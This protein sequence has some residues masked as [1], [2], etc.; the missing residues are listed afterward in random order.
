[1]ALEV[2]GA[3]SCGGWDERTEIPG[4]WRRMRPP[5][6][7]GFPASGP[8]E[9]YVVVV[10][11]ALLFCHGAF[12]YAHQLSPRRMRPRRTPH[13]R[14]AVTSQIRLGAQPGCISQTPTS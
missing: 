11:V 1:L 12:G 14:R 13:T 7:G 5:R 9:F 6:A 4:G 10:V 8:G 2:S 3:E